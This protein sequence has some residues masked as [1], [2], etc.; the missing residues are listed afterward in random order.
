MIASSATPELRTVSAKPRCSSSSGVSSSRS[1]IPSTPFIGVR[2]SWLTLATNSDF[3]RAASSASSRA[4][5]ASCSARRRSMNCPRYPA[6]EAIVASKSASRSC[7]VTSTNS[8]APRQRPPVTIGT[9]SAARKPRC[10]GTVAVAQPSSRWTSGTHT[11]SPAAHAAPTKPSPRANRIVSPPAERIAASVSSCGD[12]I[13]CM[14]MVPPSTSQTAPTSQP[15]AAQTASASRGAASST[16]VASASTRPAACS[17]SVR[18]AARTR[19]ETS[20][21][22]TVAPTIRS[23]RRTAV[24]V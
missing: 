20:R 11:G 9:A 19:S 6:I 12:H 24:T 14:R 2:I 16:V 15:S 18:R 1:A 17:A 8:S 23:P 13:A 10:R 7:A 4:M 3:R 22:A 5:T 21:M